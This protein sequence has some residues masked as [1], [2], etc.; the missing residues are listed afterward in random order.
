[1]N[2][3]QKLHKI[4]VFSF[5]LNWNL[6][7]RG[8]CSC[9]F[10]FQQRWCMSKLRILTRFSRPEPILT[11]MIQSL[12]NITG[13]YKIRLK[14]KKSQHLLT[15]YNTQFKT[16]STIYDIFIAHSQN[17]AQLLGRRGQS[18]SV[19]WSKRKSEAFPGYVTKMNWPWRPERKPYRS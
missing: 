12:N 16:S 9:F 2:M 10:V 18:V 19:T 7:A 8:E 5:S 13:H 3:A 15:I 14:K 1:M 11:I 4:T 6:H 17:I